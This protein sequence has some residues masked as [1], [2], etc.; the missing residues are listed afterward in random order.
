MTFLIEN[1]L[2][3]KKYMEEKA[4]ILENKWYMSEHA[5]KD[6]GYER[7]LLDWMLNKKEYLKQDK[8]RH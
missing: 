1:T 5:G 4:H 7:A 3:Y 8:S 6:V 2:L